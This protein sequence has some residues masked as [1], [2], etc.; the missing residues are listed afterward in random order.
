M[1]AAGG[2]R[3]GMAPTRGAHLPERGREG[4]RRGEERESRAGPVR[5]GR[6]DFLF[7]L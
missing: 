2:A 7:L 1:R 6:E 4:E 3:L 5:V